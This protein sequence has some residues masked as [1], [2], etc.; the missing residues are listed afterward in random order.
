[1]EVVQ[2]SYKHLIKDFTYNFVPGKFYVVM[3]PNGAGKSTL[4][5][6]LSGLLKP[7]SGAFYG[8]NKQPSTFFNER[9]RVVLLQ[10]KQHELFNLTVEEV[11]G[12]GRFPYINQESSRISQDKTHEQLLR[13][14]IEHLSGRLYDSLSGGE[15]QRVHLARVWNQ[16]DFKLKYGLFLIDEPFTNLDFSVYLDF[17]NELE[18]IKHF[19]SYTVILVDH[20]IGPVFNLIDEVVVLKNGEQL[21]ACSTKQL[22]ELSNL[23]SNAFEISLKVFEYESSYYLSINS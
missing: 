10:K 7:S 14:K 20:S 15:Q 1:M 17:V 21:G 2:L 13:W 4:L 3:G 23:L 9:N 16:L 22:A 12:M 5:H 19:N 8:V 11:V 18:K 6:L